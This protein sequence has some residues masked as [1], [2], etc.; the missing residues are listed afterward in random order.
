MAA[1]GKR[2]LR[3]D[4]RHG[5]PSR[6]IPNYM[7]LLHIKYESHLFISMLSLKGFLRSE[8]RGRKRRC[9]HAHPRQHQSI[10]QGQGLQRA[11]AMKPPHSPHRAGHG[12]NNEPTP[13]MAAPKDKPGQK[14]S[15]GC[16][17]DSLQQEKKNPPQLRQIQQHPPMRGSLQEHR[18][19]APL[20][21][22]GSCSGG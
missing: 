13:G 15:R 19:P 10:S 21:K 22:A 3:G 11:P 17:S 18:I 8:Q 4:S 2:A 6:L 5:S 16:S 1:Q 14:L 20:G 7:I 12:E 9:K